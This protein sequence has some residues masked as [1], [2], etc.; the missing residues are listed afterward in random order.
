MT[1]KALLLGAG[2]SYDLGMPLANGLTE[3]LFYFLTPE[4]LNRYIKIWREA[5]QYG[6]GRRIDPL[7]IDEVLDI[8]GR[9]RRDG[10]NYEE[11]LKGLQNEYRVGMEV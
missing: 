3:D 4:R 10:S 8:Y 2:F 9:S 1:K 6:P 5:D 11:F 7:A